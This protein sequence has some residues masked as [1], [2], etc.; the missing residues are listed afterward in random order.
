VIGRPAPCEV[1]REQTTDRRCDVC[2]RLTCAWCESPYPAT[3]NGTECPPCHKAHA[4]I[5]TGL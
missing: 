4:P 2:G 3:F 1:C 5:D